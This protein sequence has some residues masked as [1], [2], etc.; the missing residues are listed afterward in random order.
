MGEYA[1][2][3]VFTEISPM[4][5]FLKKQG[6][7]RFRVVFY[8]INDQEELEII[9]DYALALENC[10][11]LIEEIDL[12]CSPNTILDKFNY[13]LRRGRHH[14]V[15]VICVSQRPYGINRIITSQSNKVYSFVQK[16]PRDVS[17]LTSFFGQEAERVQNLGQYEFLLFSDSQMTRQKIVNNKLTTLK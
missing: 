15:N 7:K 5:E 2:G 11:V 9:C 1:N 8:P 10:T 6:D 3:V 14:N 4:Y 17:Y 16:E 13:L 12:Y